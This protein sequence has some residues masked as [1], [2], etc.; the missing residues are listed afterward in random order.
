MV[1]TKRGRML[2]LL[3]TWKLHPLDEQGG[4]NG[5]LH[6]Y[7]LIPHIIEPCVKQINRK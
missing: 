1:S 2:A 4:V 3:V 6:L 5:H 7:I